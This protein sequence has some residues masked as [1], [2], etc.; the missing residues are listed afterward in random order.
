MKPP[1]STAGVA[2]RMSKQKASNTDLEVQLR[3]HLYRLG[4]RYRLHTRS[5]PGTRRTVDVVFPGARVA[6]FLDGCFWHSCPVHATFPAANA[7]WWREKLA[8]NVT[9]DRD[10]DRRLA[11]AGWAVVRVWEHEDL[12]AAALRIEEV[13]RERAPRR[14]VRG[15]AVEA[16]EHGTLSAYANAGC[17]CGECRRVKAEYQQGLVDRYREAGG[18]GQHGTDYRYRTG[19]RCSPCRAAHAAADREYRARRRTSS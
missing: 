13:V 16:V 19:C 15:V 2:A 4:L 9:R 17:R 1:A 8:A 11:E 5:V 10:T 18:R 7:D 3:K 6:V 14:R 12:A